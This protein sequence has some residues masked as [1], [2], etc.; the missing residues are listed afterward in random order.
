MWER[1]LSDVLCRQTNLSEQKPEGENRVHIEEGAKTM[2][3]R[4]THIFQI[5]RDIFKES[6]RAKAWSLKMPPKLTL[7]NKAGRPSSFEN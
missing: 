2:L 3:K 5:L 1:G 6:I 7:V 4:E